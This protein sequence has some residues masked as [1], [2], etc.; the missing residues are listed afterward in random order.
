MY[1]AWWSDGGGIF[2]VS[3][4]PFTPFSTGSSLGTHI[5]DGTDDGFAISFN[6]P[7][8]D[9]ITKICFMQS[10]TDGTDTSLSWY[11]GVQGLGT[12]PDDN[13]DGIWK[14]NGGDCKG[15]FTKPGVASS[16][17]TLQI[18][19]LDNAYP[20]TK[21]E[22]LTLVIEYNTGTISSS[23]DISI[24]DG[25]HSAADT[26]AVGLVWKKINTSYPAP[27]VPDF[28]PMGF[29]T[30]AGDRFGLWMS[31]PVSSETGQNA[32]Q[33]LKFT[34]PAGSYKIHGAIWSCDTQSTGLN[35]Q[36]MVLRSDTDNSD[37]LEAQADSGW[38]FHDAQGGYAGT[39][40]Y[41]DTPISIEGETE[42]FIGMRSDVGSG[43]SRLL[44]FSFDDAT[45]R[46]C[47]P[48]CRAAGNTSWHYSVRSDAG[49][50]TDTTTAVPVVTLILESVSS[51]GGGSSGGTKLVGLGGL[52]G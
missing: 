13:P 44:Y 31:S 49:V 21:N 18:V 33:G 37:I 5:L 51:G 2:L 52:V 23:N 41:F 8:N 6:A 10:D 50:Y 25:T 9:S 38:W 42:Y 7:N 4:S 34:L 35:K 36:D 45:Y 17:D 22:F 39:P 32:Y 28:P 19:T 43:T 12:H 26:S 24:Y 40:G 11:V 16:V 48:A 15:T 20:M 14:T 47:I 3:S 1:Q 27:I 29:E 30:D 46:Y